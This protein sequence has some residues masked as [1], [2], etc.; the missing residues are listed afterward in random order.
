[1]IGLTILAFRYEGLRESDFL[2]FMKDI[3]QKMWNEEG[4][5]E[6]RPTAKLFGEWVLM[7]GGRVR[8]MRDLEKQVRIKMQE[9]KSRIFYS[10]FFF[11]L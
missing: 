8:G 2:T 11:L 5:Y 6:K 3:Q 1:M 10:H 9:N 4:A 7:A